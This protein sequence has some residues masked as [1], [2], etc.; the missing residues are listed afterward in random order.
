MFVYQLSV[1]GEIEHVEIA[2]TPG[3]AKYQ[4]YRYLQDGIW[5]APFGEIV[6][7]MKCKKIGQASIKHLFENKEQFERICKG[8]GISFAYQGMK[9]E[10]AGQL[11][12]I[13]GA[14]DS[15]N[16]QVVMDGEWTAGNCHPWWETRYFD[17]DGNVITDYRKQAQVN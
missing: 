16:L 7:H 3:K 2:A 13:V 17:K 1:D 14:N 8:R 11:G 9:I 4:Y 12:T 10:V 6:K 5:E 15:C